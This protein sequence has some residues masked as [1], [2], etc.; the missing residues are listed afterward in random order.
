MLILGPKRPIIFE[1]Q[2]AC[3]LVSMDTP[4]DCRCLKLLY[5]KLKS[6]FHCTIL[7]RDVASQNAGS[8]YFLP[9]LGLEQ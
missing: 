9:A 8:F 3:R 2:F 6:R 4:L 5:I 7:G 1:E